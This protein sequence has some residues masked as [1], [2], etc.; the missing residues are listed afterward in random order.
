MTTGK[1]QR[2]Q[3]TWTEFLEKM[4][5]DGPRC[6]TAIPLDKS[7]TTTHTFYPGEEP[8]MEEWIAERDGKENLYFHINPVM[9]RL[10]KKARRENIKAWGCRPGP[11]IA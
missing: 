1:T 10:K 5:G 2:K 3:R 4:C 9:G 8:E 11:W 7:G 6:L